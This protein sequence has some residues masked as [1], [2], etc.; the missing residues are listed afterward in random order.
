MTVLEAEKVAALIEETS[1]CTSSDDS[2]S[3]GDSPQCIH[4]GVEGVIASNTDE[5]EES[6]GEFPELNT[7]DIKL[8]SKRS[9]V[10]EYRKV[11]FSNVHVKE[12]DRV[13]G[14]NPSCSFGVPIT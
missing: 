13:V 14:D 5:S 2:F 6:N 4:Y 9:E 10:R 11:S 12:F 7:E 8:S 1:T 3:S